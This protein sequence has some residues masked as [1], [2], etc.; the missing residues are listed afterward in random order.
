M[1]EE[2][3]GLKLGTAA[4]QSPTRSKRTQSALKAQPGQAPAPPPAPPGTQPGPWQSRSRP[5]PRSPPRRPQPARAPCA[6][7]GGAQRVTAQPSQLAAPRCSPGTTSQAAAHAAALPACIKRCAV[8]KRPSIC[9]RAWRARCPHLSSS[10]WSQMGISKSSG[11]SS[12]SGYKK[13]STSDRTS[14]G[15]GGTRPAEAGGPGGA[16]SGRGV[17]WK[18]GCTPAAGRHSGG[19]NKCRSWTLDVPA[20]WQAKKPRMPA[21]RPPS[22][23]PLAVARSRSPH[24]LPPRYRTAARQNALH[25]SWRSRCTAAPTSGQPLALLWLRRCPHPPP[26]RP[27]CPRRCRAACEP[28]LEGGQRCAG[29]AGVRA[30]L[31]AAGSVGGQAPRL[32][33]AGGLHCLQAAVGW[34][35]GGWVRGGAPA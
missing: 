18:G 28:A 25:S 8:G 11:S 6:A 2:L 7:G 1:G 12:G 3:G 35:V 27:S 13:L 26:P 31:R 4:A 22:Q 10:R 29:G 32:Q 16:G 15:C 9:R 19:C 30:A 21:A 14:S 20:S 23:L 24:K 33:G 5:A 34:S 17:A